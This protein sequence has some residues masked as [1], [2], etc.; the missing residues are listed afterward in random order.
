MKACYYGIKKKPGTVNGPWKK[1]VVQ[2]QQQLPEP[3]MSQ[4]MEPS[5][6]RKFCLS[7]LKTNYELM[8]GSSI[9]KND[10][11]KHYLNS[12]PG[13]RSFY[14]EQHFG[15]CVRSI[16]G[17]SI[18]PN[19]K[20]CADGIVKFYYDGIQL[21]TSKLNLENQKTSL[22]HSKIE[23]NN[24]S[25]EEYQNTETDPLSIE[26]S[27]NDDLISQTAPQNLMKR[28]DSMK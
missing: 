1:H 5:V 9:E 27:N 26:N 20:Q 24:L 14:S 11:Y 12:V 16:F 23:E 15:V 19:K 4:Q 22:N 13:L 8:N 7:W 18:G 25:A 10:M 17:G 21:R 28:K 2:N 6:D 3:Q